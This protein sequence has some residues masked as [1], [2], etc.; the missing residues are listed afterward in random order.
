VLALHAEGVF[1][2]V[3]QASAFG[4]AGAL[5]TVS[6]GLF[7]TWGGARTAMAT[8]ATG[9]LTYAVASLV[10]AEL[11]FLMS[12]AASLGCYVIAAS[13]ERFA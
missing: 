8:L 1:A 6:F 11:P 3:E 5:V 7:T 12:L 13:L 9:I 2:L 10:G 4:S